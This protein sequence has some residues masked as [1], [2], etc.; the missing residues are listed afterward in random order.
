[1][2]STHCLASIL[3]KFLKLF[4]HGQALQLLTSWIHT[5]KHPR[6]IWDRK[7][8]FKS[9]WDLTRTLLD[10]LELSCALTLWSDSQMLLISLLLARIFMFL[11]FWVW[12]LLRSLICVKRHNF[13]LVWIDLD[14]WGANSTPQNSSRLSLLFWSIGTYMTIQMLD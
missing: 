2:I 5:C 10:I 4:S 1:M 11:K 7:V 9:T 12:N 14:I 6:R 3:N 13:I 8:V